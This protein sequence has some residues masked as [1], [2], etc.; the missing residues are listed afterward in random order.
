[1]NTVTALVNMPVLEPILIE[2]MCS[3]VTKEMATMETTLQEVKGRE[4]NLE[5]VREKCRKCQV[6]MML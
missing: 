6:S 2:Q 5:V 3:N 1:M 4:L